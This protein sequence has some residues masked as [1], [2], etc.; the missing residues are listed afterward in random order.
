MEF[1]RKLRKYRIFRYTPANP[2]DGWEFSAAMLERFCGH[3]GI[4]LFKRSHNLFN[5]LFVFPIC[6]FIIYGF[7]VFITTYRF[8]DDITKVI[9]CLTTL[10]FASQAIMK[11]Y[12]FIITRKEVI[13][14]NETNH[15]FYRTMMKQSD[16]VKGV[17][18]E[19][20]G[21]IYI[22]SRLA[23]I[24]YMVLELTVL[25]IPAVSSSL[26][27]TEPLLPFGY[28][29]PFIDPDTLPGYLWNY[30]FQLLISAYYWYITVS[31]D[32]QTI[33]NLLTA[34]GQLDVLM[35]LIDELNEDLANGKPQAM[36]KGKI[37]EIIQ[38]HQQHR[39]Y[40]DR[41]VQ[42]LNLYHLVAV[43]CSVLAMVI[44]VL[45]LV[46]L[47]W[48]PGIAMV[49][50]GSSQLF[51]VC[52]LGTSLDIKLDELTEKAGA[53]CWDKLSVVEMK[54]MKLVLAMSQKPKVLLVATAPLNMNAF[55]QIHKMIYSMVMML[56]NTKD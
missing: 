35:T 33:Y 12:S 15:K 44:S 30:V 6:N 23:A 55:V 38:L 19:N 26:R 40:L 34:C 50:L 24:A 11:I 8:R 1:L 16:R 54:Y 46:L 42:F 10:G 7:S 22:V 32:I 48:Y 4:S 9:H 51:Y 2:L 43:G 20:I 53:V 37:I 45:G 29:F 39:E 17:L 49:F 5:F 14:I 36:I 18:C 25:I 13:D 47:D 21:L 31:T 52:F 56:R 3:I 41:V 27:I 28:F